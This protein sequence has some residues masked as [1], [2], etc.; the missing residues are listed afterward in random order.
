ML[1]A[2]GLSVFDIRLMIYLEILIRMVISIINGVLLGI[3]FSLGL[4]GQIEEILMLKAPMPKLDVVILIAAALL[5]V[6]S[7]TVIQSTHYL[8]KR[9][10]AQ[11]AS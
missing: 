10:V 11:T 5:I 4:S 3:L 2:V 1:R 9:T 8:T 6:F 7:F